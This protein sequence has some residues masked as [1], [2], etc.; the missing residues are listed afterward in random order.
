M[1][2]TFVTGAS[3]GIGRSL[4]KRIA[5]AGDA[6]AVVARRKELLDTLVAEI[7]QTGGKA[8]AISCDVT[9]RDAVRDAVRMAEQRLG[10]TTTLIANAGGQTP[11][12]VANFRAADIDD[13]LRLNVVGVANC[14]EA[15]L[16]GMLERRSG[17]LVATSSLAAYRGLPGAGGYSAAKAALTNMMESLRIDLRGTGVDVTVIAPGFIRTK[18]KKKKKKNRPFTLELEPATQRMHRAITLRRPYYA[19]PKSLLLVMWL[20]WALP[21][22]MY[23]RVLAGRGPK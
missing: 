11:F 7:E 14:V 10:P 9:D 22:R 13:A 20:G 17:H 12:D 4:A 19:F 3:S 18:P 23:D 8:L 2:M 5:A 16:P 6:V 21:A 15:V 1:G